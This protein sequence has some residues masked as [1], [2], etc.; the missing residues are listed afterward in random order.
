M[1]TSPSRSVTTYAEMSVQTP[2]SL[3]S[4]TVLRR[5]SGILPSHLLKL[6]TQHSAKHGGEAILIQPQGVVCIWNE[7]SRRVGYK[8]FGLGAFPNQ[9]GFSRPA[10]SARVAAGCP[11]TSTGRACCLHGWDIDTRDGVN[12]LDDL[13]DPVGK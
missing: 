13:V 1:P 8:Q 2:P 5:Y 9:I 11:P 12:N 4:I 3:A 6:L 7:R 10:R